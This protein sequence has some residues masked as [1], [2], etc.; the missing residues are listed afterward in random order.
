[1]PDWGNYDPSCHAA[2]KKKSRQ[3]K[4]KNTK[5]PLCSFL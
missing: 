5:N 2:K 1:M 4:M 3:N